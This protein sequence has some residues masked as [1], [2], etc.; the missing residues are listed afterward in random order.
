MLLNGFLLNHQPGHGGH[1][2]RSP[3]LGIGKL[4][5]DFVLDVPGQDDNIGR[6]FAAQPFFGHNRDP[7][8]G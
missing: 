6:P 2:P 1:E 5:H 4:L 7:A 8:A 3:F